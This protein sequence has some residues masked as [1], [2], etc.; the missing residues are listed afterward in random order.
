MNDRKGLLSDRLVRGDVI[1]CV[2]EALVDLW[3][4]HKAVDLNRVGALDLDCFQ[5]G[6]IDNEVVALGDLVAA[7]FIFGATGARVPSSIS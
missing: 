1:W 6:I 7:A 3:A 5:L 2:E 4:R